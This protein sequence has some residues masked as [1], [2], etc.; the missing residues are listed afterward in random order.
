MKR[1][2]YLCMFLIVVFVMG[3]CLPSTPE[4]TNTPALPPTP[5]RPRAATPTKPPTPE[6]AKA[7]TPHPS[8]PADPKLAFHT[9]RDGNNEIYVM[10]ADGS[11][12]T[13]LTNH[14]ANDASPAWSP[15][16]QRIAFQSDRNGV[17]NLYIMRADGSDVIRL[18]DSAISNVNP[19]W[20]PDGSRLAFT[21]EEH[22]WQI[23]IINADGTGEVQITDLPAFNGTPDWAPTGP[24]SIAFMNEDQHYSSAIHNVRADGT[25]MLRLT[26]G[27]TYHDLQPAWSPDGEQ[28]AFASERV[29]HLKFE[30]FISAVRQ[31]QDEPIPQARQ[32]TNTGGTAQSP[33]WSPFLPDGSTRI[34]FSARLDGGKPDI[35]LVSPDG[36]DLVRLTDHPATDAAPSWSP[37][38]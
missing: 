9:D 32:I 4:P 23:H 5:T 22:G 1:W 10:D 16:G 17:P 37:L 12:P 29:A 15:D 30:L 2:L 28:M 27:G 19:A 3:A 24:A 38:P 7:G 13:N 11:D 36:S 25:A 8:S 14:P 6:P 35:Y 34:A 33:A 18:T 21:S 20:A 26:S 31:S